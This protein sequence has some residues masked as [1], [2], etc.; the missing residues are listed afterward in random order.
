MGLHVILPTIRIYKLCLPHK[1]Q[2][3]YESP[4]IEEFDTLHDRFALG[5]YRQDYR[6]VCSRSFTPEEAINVLSED[7]DIDSDEATLRFNKLVNSRNL[8]WTHGSLALIG[9]HARL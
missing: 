2:S 9:H 6:E 7:L 4:T 3:G 1:S 8:V 5:K